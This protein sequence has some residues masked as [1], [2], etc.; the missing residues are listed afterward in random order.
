MKETCGIRLKKL[1]EEVGYTQIELAQEIKISNVVINRY[2]N[3][4]V[5]P[6]YNFMKKLIIHFNVNINWLLLGL[7]KMFI[8]REV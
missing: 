6:N 2:A 5:K 3:D 8:P 4:R 7:G 1:I